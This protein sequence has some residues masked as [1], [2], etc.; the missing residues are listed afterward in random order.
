MMLPE[1]KEILMRGFDTLQKITHMKNNGSLEEVTY[2]KYTGFLVF[3][4]AAIPINVSC[5]YNILDFHMDGFKGLI[6]FFRDDHFELLPPNQD[7]YWVEVRVPYKGDLEKD[8]DKHPKEILE[9]LFGLPGMIKAF[10]QVIDAKFSETITKAYEDRQKS[11]KGLKR[12][13]ELFFAMYS[14]IGGITTIEDIY[15]VA[16]EKW[17]DVYPD[18]YIIS[19]TNSLY[20]KAKAKNPNLVDQK[21]MYKYSFAQPI[22]MFDILSDRFNSSLGPDEQ[23]TNDDDKFFQ[24]VCAEAF[25]EYPWPNTPKKAA[26]NLINTFG[27]K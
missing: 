27:S 2:P 19:A 23:I 7:H 14:E 22:E 11:I 20:R 15:S 6:K 21:F 26:Y 4:P 10:K 1:Y 12:V 16:H 9:Y 5:I 17:G 18:H 8:F 3:F 25:N 13:V 24:K